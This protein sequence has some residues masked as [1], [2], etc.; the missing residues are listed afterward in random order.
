MSSP[1]TKLETRHWNGHHSK[2]CEVYNIDLQGIVCRYTNKMLCSNEKRRTMN[3][4]LEDT[5]KL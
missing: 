1:P 2:Q 3:L 5:F 4:S